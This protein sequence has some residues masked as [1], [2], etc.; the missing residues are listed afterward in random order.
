MSFNLYGDHTGEAYSNFG[1]TKVLYNCSRKDVDLDSNERKR[2]FILILAFLAID[3]QWLAHLRS[4]LI[5]T[6]RSL[7]EDTF[8]RSMLLIE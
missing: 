7:I 2:Q 3:A 1:R 5:I 6:P 4:L 8:T